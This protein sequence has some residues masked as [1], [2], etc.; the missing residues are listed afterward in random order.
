MHFHLV[1]YTH[2]PEPTTA[3]CHFPTASNSHIQK[4]KIIQRHASPSKT[5]KKTIS[6]HFKQKYKQTN[7]AS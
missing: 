1:L 7:L 6:L 3:Q 5:L 2:Y 4:S